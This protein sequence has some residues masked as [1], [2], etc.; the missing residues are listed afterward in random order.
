MLKQNQKDKTVRI[1]L[2][3]GPRNISTALMYSFAQ[4]DDTKVFDEPL[5]GHYLKNTDA[6]KYHPGAAEIMQSMD[7][8]GKRVVK[9]MLSEHDK[10]VLF[11]KNM[12]HHLLDLNRDFL[13]QVVNVFLTRDP[14]DMIPSF[15]NVIKNPTLA[16]IG[17]KDHV[18]L[19]DYLEQETIEPIVLDSSRILDNPENTLRVLCE[20]IGID[21]QENMLSWEAG[22]RKEDGIWAQYW[23]DN[24]HRST[25]FT[26]YRKKDIPFPEQLKPL[27]DVC[28]P[29]YNRLQPYVIS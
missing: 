28:M 15:A 20:R 17:Y 13:K 8:N 14:L 10:P 4:R 24:V 11:F 21:F 3:S 2:W 12:T 7:T 9:N 16:D 18:D 23:Y 5:Y 19:I 1:C 25:G 26:K 22:S 6:K 27:L 29:Y